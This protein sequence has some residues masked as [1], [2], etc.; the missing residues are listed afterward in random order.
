[1]SS[2]DDNYSLGTNLTDSNI[3]TIVS[4]AIT[5]NKLPKDDS[6]AYFVLT[7]AD[8]SETSGFCTTYCG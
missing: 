5:S 4:N 7:S 3:A 6:G 8:V 1:M 2:I